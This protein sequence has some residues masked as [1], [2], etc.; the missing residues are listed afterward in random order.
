[1]S[2]W[3]Y[4]KSIGKIPKGFVI[5]HKCDNP[6]C[7]NIDHLEIGTQKDNVQDMMKR[8][9][10]GYKTIFTQ[11]STNPSAKLD[12]SKVRNIL[13]QYSSGN[14]ITKIAF[15]YGVSAKTI[16]NIVHH[17]KWQHIGEPNFRAR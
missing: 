7:I 1:M 16:S 5:R 13:E 15:E 3:L 14:K 11:G 8:G 10:N 12:E 9:R 6:K 2:R 4:E 17:K